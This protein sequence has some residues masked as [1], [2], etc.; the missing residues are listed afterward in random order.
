MAL[1]NLEIIQ[2]IPNLVTVQVRLRSSERTYTY[3]APNTETYEEGDLVVVEVP[4]TYK[5]AEVVSSA[6]LE[7]SHLLPDVDYKFLV[8]KVG[9][10]AY[11]G[12]QERTEALRAHIR[13]MEVETLRA[14]AKDKLSVGCDDQSKT[15]LEAM[16]K[17]VVKS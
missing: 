6:P 14:Q 1:T 4:N 16:L 17:G 9:L 13:S 11:R 15:T 8:G 7:G 5:V 12:L 2:L 3:L 10:D